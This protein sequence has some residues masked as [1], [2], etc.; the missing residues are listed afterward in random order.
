MTQTKSSNSDGFGKEVAVLE[1]KATRVEVFTGPHFPNK[2]R[3]IWVLYLGG[4]DIV[5]VSFL[6]KML[7]LHNIYLH[8]E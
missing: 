7:Q 1:K 8:N 6:P 2:Y 5:T 3:S 4:Q